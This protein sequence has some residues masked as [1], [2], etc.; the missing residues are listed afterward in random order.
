VHEHRH[1]LAVQQPAQ[2]AAHDVDDAP[3][4]RVERT[5]E[6]LLGDAQRE[7]DGLALERLR[8]PLPLG[9]EAASA[10]PA[11]KPA[12]RAAAASASRSTCGTGGAAMAPGIVAATTSTS[13]SSGGSSKGSGPAA[14][15]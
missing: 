10:I 12:S 4:L 9:L 5:P 3:G 7:L 11:A 2:R 14:T 15:R 8:G 6:H 1:A 13:G